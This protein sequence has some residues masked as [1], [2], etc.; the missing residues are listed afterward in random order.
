MNFSHHSPRVSVLLPVRNGMPWLPSAIDSVLRQTLDDLELIVLEDGS[1]DSTAQ[2]LGMLRDER[3]RIIPTGGVGIA[4]AL[5]AG[6]A[7]AR[8]ALVARQDADDESLP[9]R[10][11]CQAGILD[12]LPEIDVVATAAEYIDG[13]ET[14]VDDEWVRTV[15]RQ[16]DIARLPQ[17]IAELMP[18]TCCVTHGSIVARTGCPARGRWLSSRTGAG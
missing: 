18:L 3:L 12:A 5:N 4:R 7:A 15:R 16:Q 14:R 17:A 9:N 6:L 1:T 10:L 2:Y 8:G 13:T 11:H